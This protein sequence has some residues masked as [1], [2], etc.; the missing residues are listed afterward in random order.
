MQNRRQDLKH[1]SLICGNTAGHM[2]K[3]GFYRAKNPHALETK[4]NKNLPV[5]WQHNLKAW[6][7]VVLFNE[8]FHQCSSWSQGIFGRGRVVIKN[9]QITDNTPGH[10]HSISIEEE[11]VQVV[12]SPLNTTSLLQPLYQGMIRCV[13]AS[14]TRQIFEMFRVVI[15][16]EPS[17]QVMDC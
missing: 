17:I 15:D 4:T 13:K 2:I 6:V 7:T 10:P 8:W 3:P 16:A 9:L 5:F 14:Y 11:N 1:G 12:F